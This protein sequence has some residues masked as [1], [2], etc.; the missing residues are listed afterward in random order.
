[1][2]R[3]VFLAATFVAMA[4][5]AQQPAAPKVVAV[6]NGE[7]ITVEDLDRLYGKLPAQMR[8]NYENNGGKGQFL[9]QYINK[10]LLVQEAMKQNFAKDEYVAKMLADAREASIFDL[11]VKE[12][13]ADNVISEKDLRDYYE[14]NKAEYTTPERIK[15]RHIIATPLQ[16]KVQNTTG[17]NAKNELE[18]KNKINDIYTK[19]NLTPATFGAAAMRFSEDASAPKSGDLGWFERGKMVAEFEEVAF[20]LKP[21]EISAPV[22]TQFGWHLIMVEA[23]KPASVH[24]FEE[25]RRQVQEKLLAERADKILMEVNSLTQE[26]RR[27]SRVQINLGTL[28][29]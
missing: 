9:E 17:D 14:K 11:Y 24:P 29:Q 15:A 27:Q 26:L 25:V 28:E 6:V 10:R 5:Q 8:E 20:S 13:V 22:K 18:A 21:G 12:V 19:G 23:H 3:V 2:K 1:M 4:A 16:Q 7:T